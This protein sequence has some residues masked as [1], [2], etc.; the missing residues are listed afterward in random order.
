[1]NFVKLFTLVLSVLIVVLLSPTTVGDNRNC[2][3][4]LSIPSECHFL[5][6]VGSQ[7]FWT[8]TRWRCTHKY[9]AKVA[10]C[11]VNNKINYVKLFGKELTQSIKEGFDKLSESLKAKLTDAKEFVKATVNELLSIPQDVLSSLQESLSGMTS[12]QFSGIIDRLTSFTSQNLKKLIAHMN[13]DSFF[14]NID[15]IAVS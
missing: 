12:S 9:Y 10:T 6:G 8:I 11:R 15:K 14:D 13:L 4:Q 3:T 5:C 2:C 7:P 1:M